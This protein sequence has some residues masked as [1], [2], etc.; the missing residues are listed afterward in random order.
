MVAGLSRQNLDQLTVRVLRPAE[1]ARPEVR[2]VAVDG[3]WW[4]VKDYAAGGANLFKRLLGMYLV[5]RE[6]IAYQK[7]AGVDG[8]P[9]LGG[10]L[11]VCAL[12]T[13]YVEATEATSAARELLT[14]EFFD[15]LRTVISDLHRHGVV[16]AD[17]K[18]LENV[19]VTP[20]G[21]PVLVDF[22]AAFVTGS[23]P[24]TAS[25]FPWIGD[26]DLRAVTKLKKR[27]APE[28]VTEEE[29][30]FLNERSGIERFFRWSRRY[31]RYAVKRYSSPEHERVHVRLK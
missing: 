3:H 23:N 6:H 24:L 18:K 16:H 22:T 26:D 14:A 11:G 9:A 4:V 12:V 5:A 2:I 17:L 25:L 15:R 1:R 10:T 31:V 7:A 8:V 20:E 30:Q 28:L 19:L 29:E 21:R 27:C 13:E